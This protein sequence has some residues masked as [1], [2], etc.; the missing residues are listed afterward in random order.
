MTK[1]P[2]KNEG[3]EGRNIT[4]ISGMAGICSVGRIAV[5][6]IAAQFN[7]KLVASMYLDDLPAHVTIDENGRMNLPVVQLYLA[8]PVAQQAFLLVTSDYQPSSNTGMFNFVDS[9]M[10]YLIETNIS[11]I[12]SLGAF[13]VEQIPSDPKIFVSGTDEAVIAKFLAIDKKRTIRM[14][15]GLISGANGLIPAW[16]AM[17]GLPGICLLAETVPIVKRDPKAARLVIEVLSKHFVFPFDFTSI[18]KEIKELEAALADF[19]RGAPGAVDITE[20]NARRDRQSY[21]G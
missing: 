8:K 4:L 6:A 9:L 7:A 3:I 17:L 16:G 12:I 10:N 20:Q 18:D 19:Q 13:V 2:L 1:N 5:D 11:L 21:I 14:E 15:N